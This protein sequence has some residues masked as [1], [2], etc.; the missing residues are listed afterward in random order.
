MRRL[1]KSLGFLT[2]VCLFGLLS[3]NPSGDLRY[4][5]DGW[6][7]RHWD[8][9][10]SV[11]PACALPRSG[12]YP[13]GGSAG[14]YTLTGPTTGNIDVASQFTVKGN[15]PTTV[16]ITPSDT[17]NHGVFS[18][19]TVNLAGVNPVTFNYSPLQAG[20]YNISTT[21]GGALT[22]PTPISYTVSNLASS[23]YP[24]LTATW[25][26]QNGS[27]ITTGQTG[28][29]GGTD[30]AKITEDSSLN[31]HDIDYS[32][33]ISVNTGQTYTLSVMVKEG[34]GTRNI[35]VSFVAPDSSSALVAAFNASTGAFLG[36][37]SWGSATLSSTNTLSLGSGWFLVQVSGTMGTM[38]SG[39]YTIWM[40]SGSNGVGTYTGDGASNILVSRTTMQ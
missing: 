28:P 4:N 6:T 8:L 31:Y 37:G 19:T 12:G 35:D 24:G 38:T 1:F 10:P 15:G 2:T 11:K 30:A 25:A 33:A 39:F 26:V 21:N 32:S 22:N 13:C 29:F 27:T 14:S 7:V 9:A 3:F 34:T 20:T 16:L 17:S 5:V 18:P 36:D 40:D 23:G